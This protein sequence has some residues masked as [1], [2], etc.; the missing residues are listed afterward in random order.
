MLGDLDQ[1]SQESE[2]FRLENVSE[3]Q[4]RILVNNTEAAL[5]DMDSLRIWGEKAYRI[6]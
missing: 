3:A 5:L 1:S 2:S 6:G 4:K